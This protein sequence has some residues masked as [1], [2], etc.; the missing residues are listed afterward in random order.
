MST[1]TS[2]EVDD[3]YPWR[4][5]CAKKYSTKPGY[6][7]H[8]TKCPALKEHCKYLLRLL[9]YLDLDPFPADLLK[10]AFH[11]FKTWQV[12]GKTIDE[13]VFHYPASFN[14]ESTLSDGIQGGVLITDGNPDN[15]QDDVWWE[16]QSF[17]ILPLSKDIIRLDDNHWDQIKLDALRFVVHIFPTRD[18]D[19]E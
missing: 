14:I 19:D 13:R 3:R 16:C 5:W 15:Q 7:R 2:F 1:F 6:Q 8:M 10:R 11:P 4:C 17:R 12:D 9:V 18:F